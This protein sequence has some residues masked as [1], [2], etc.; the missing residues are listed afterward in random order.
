MKQIF[1]VPLEK[2]PKRYSYEW[3]SH[4][5]SMITSYLSNEGRTCSSAFIDSADDYDYYENLGVDFCVYSIVGESASQTTQS[6]AFINFATT[7]VF[8]SSQASII[9]Q[10]FSTGRVR[11]GATFYF[12]DSWNPTILQV[13]YMA[14]LLGIDVKIHGQWHA[15]AHD[16]N[17]ML[18]PTARWAIPTEKALFLAIDVNY[19][20]TDYYRNLFYHTVVPEY[21]GQEFQSLRVGYPLSYVNGLT[22]LPGTEVKKERVVLFPHRIAPEKNYSYLEYL[23]PRL[24]EHNIELDVCQLNDYSKL[25]YEYALKR[26]SVSVSFALQETY[27]IAQVEAL[28]SNTIPY[29]PYRLSYAEMYRDEFLHDS[30]RSINLKAF[31]ENLDYFVNEIVDRVDNYSSYQEPMRLNQHYINQHY[32]GDSQIVHSITG[33]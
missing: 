10:L 11:N 1:I 2:N 26:A 33:V 20:T 27:G 13:R 30:D 19:F 17:D 24:Q 14:D 29:S 32:I 4:I 9:A 21:I 16:P 12:T 7:N 23:K 22:P 15:G 3:F 28:M 6:N 25:D 5:P 31:L 8:K 18:A